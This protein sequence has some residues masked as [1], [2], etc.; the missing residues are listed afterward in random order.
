VAKRLLIVKACDDVCATE[1]D[2][3]KNIAEMFGMTHCLVDLVGMDEFKK[4]LCGG[5]KYDYLYL[6]AH[7]SPFDF[8]TADGKVSITWSDLSVALCETQCLNP[9]AIL[10]LGCCRGGLRRVAETLFFNCDQIDYVCGPRWTVTSHDLTAG[11]H[12]F[13]YN[14][15]S[16]HEQ[17]STAVR[18]ASGATGYDFFCYDRVEVED[19][20]QYA[21]E[22]LPGTHND[23]DV[24]GIAPDAEPGAAPDPT[25]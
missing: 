17:P 18:R 9:E 20:Y 23:A 13:I 1:I 6:A 4:K 16:R 7:A 5:D 14:M 22:T 15:E 3:L 12:V 10:L 21:H 2:H 8:G 19:H 25:I 24:S 11:F